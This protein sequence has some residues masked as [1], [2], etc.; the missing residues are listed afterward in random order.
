MRKL[1]W[2]KKTATGFFPYLLKSH[3]LASSECQGDTFN[4]GNKTEIEP[5]FA[6]LVQ[7]AVH[8]LRNTRL[9][10]ETSGSFSDS[11]CYSIRFLD[12]NEDYVLKVC[13]LAQKS[14][15]EFDLQ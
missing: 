9:S 3:Q 13:F 8:L 2:E 5:S 10:T 11:D 12:I 4:T 6:S 1:L 15:D 7:A 14:C